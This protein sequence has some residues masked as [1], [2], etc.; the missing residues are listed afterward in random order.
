MCLRFKIRTYQDKL[1][2]LTLLYEIDWLCIYGN[3]V[4]D[5]K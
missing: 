4:R 2:R 1:Y 5:L 3:F